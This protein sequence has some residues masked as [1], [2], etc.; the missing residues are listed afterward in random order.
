MSLN[1]R[2][3]KKIEIDYQ[4]RRK[5]LVDGGEDTGV[6]LYQ[7]GQVCLQHGMKA[8]AADAYLA[9]AR[10][11]NISEEALLDMAS[12]FEEAESWGEARLCCE[13]LLEKDP[14]SRVQTAGE[15]GGVLQRWL[16][17]G[18]AS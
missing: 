8:E 6:K 1:R 15:V 9:A 5:S 14:A 2:R 3:I 12:F 7:L 18:T 13:K 4:Q 17:G 10:K 11:D 16:E